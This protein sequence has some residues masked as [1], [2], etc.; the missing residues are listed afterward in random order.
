MAYMTPEDKAYIEHL[1]TTMRTPTVGKIA[2]LVGRN[3]ATVSY[4][5]MSRCL[6]EKPILRG[7]GKTAYTAEHDA[8]LLQL[9]TQGMKCRAIAEAVTAEFGIR[10]DCHSVRCR[11][12]RLAIAPEL[13]Q[14]AA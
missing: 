3:R 8:R 5:L 14:E 11:L 2:R 10:R 6:I 4:Y 9:R 7:N 1:A 12:L 13:E